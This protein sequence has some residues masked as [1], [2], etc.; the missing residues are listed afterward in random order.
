MINL[1]AKNV[2]EKTARASFVN[3]RVRLL[4]PGRI[5]M[6]IFGHLVFSFF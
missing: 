4:K 6:G 2:P 1:T 5:A 3:H